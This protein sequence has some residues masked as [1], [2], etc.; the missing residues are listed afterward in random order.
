MAMS[1]SRYALLLL[2]D[3]F[4]SRKHGVKRA[5]FSFVR[6]LTENCE[7]KVDVAQGE[8]SFIVKY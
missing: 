8:A 2:Y 6:L 5:S 1:G 7:L 3:L 4:L